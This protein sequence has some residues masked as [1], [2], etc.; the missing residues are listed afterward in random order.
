MRS[1]MKS[2]R[3]VA[4]KNSGLHTERRRQKSHRVSCAPQRVDVDDSVTS[5]A[6]WLNRS[7]L[8]ERANLARH[9]FAHRAELLRHRLLRHAKGDRRPLHGP[10][11]QEFGKPR[12]NAVGRSLVETID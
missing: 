10:R 6:D 3:G 5:V 7:T 2:P 11:E 9:D 4:R 8:D 1:R 12:L